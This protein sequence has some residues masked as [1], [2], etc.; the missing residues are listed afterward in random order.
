MNYK[1]WQMRSKSTKTWKIINYR[2]I[3]RFANNQLILRFNNILLLTCQK[4]R[5][6]VSQYVTKDCRINVN[7]WSWNCF[8]KI[9]WK[10]SP[11]E[12]FLSNNKIITSGSNSKFLNWTVI[13]SNR[14]HW[15][16]GLSGGDT[17]YN[18]ASLSLTHKREKKSVT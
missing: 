13:N 12:Y 3:I 17:N 8:M 5:K 4:F 2:T 1:K 16:Q 9:C 18:C 14:M 6:N 7:F 15:C 10:M 11:K